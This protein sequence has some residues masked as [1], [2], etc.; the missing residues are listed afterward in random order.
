MR[1]EYNSLVANKTWDLVCKPS[2]KKI[3]GCKWVFATKR[4]ADGDVEKYK[5]RLVAQG[6]FQKRNED[7]FETYA[8]VVRHPT[9]RLILALAVQNK[10]LINHIDIAA[11][12]LNGQLEE[13]MPTGVPMLLIESHTVGTL[14]TLL[15]VQSPGNP[16][17]KTLLH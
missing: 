6:C 14:F 2:N 16:N 4:N 3:I 13:E 10:L 12:Y 5:A 11:A 1:E 15:V 8:P 9:I 17:N 7:F